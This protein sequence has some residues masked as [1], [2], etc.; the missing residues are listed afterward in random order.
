MR[1]NTTT[2]LKKEIHNRFGVR[3]ARERKRRHWTQENLKEAL[4]LGSTLAITRWENGQSTPRA[5]MLKKL[6]EL[7]G[8][9]ETWG[10]ERAQ[11]WTIPF[12]R[13]LYFTGREASWQ[14][15]MN[16]CKKAPWR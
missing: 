5:D 3:L 1:K 9:E 13:N 4:K 16:W 7:F 11:F 2:S 8:P 12:M 15:C 6:V 14:P 10:A